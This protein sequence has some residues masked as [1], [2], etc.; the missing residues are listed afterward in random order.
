MLDLRIRILFNTLVSM[1]GTKNAKAYF[2]M[3]LAQGLDSTALPLKFIRAIVITSLFTYLSA[4]LLILF[5]D[6][7]NLRRKFK[8]GLF[9]Q[10]WEQCD[11]RISKIKVDI[12]REKTTQ[13]TTHQQERNRQTGGQARSAWTKMRGRKGWN[14][15]SL[16]SNE[17]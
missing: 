17:V 10:V 4:A 13:S 5:V 2:S 12:E 14:M 1:T 6:R 16:F 15:R 7:K 9:N 11:I 8:K 3:P